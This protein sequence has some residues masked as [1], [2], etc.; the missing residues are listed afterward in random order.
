MSLDQT[1]R[2]WETF[3][4]TDPLW[5]VLGDPTRKGNR[6]NEEE[7]YRT[8]VD[9]VQRTMD[10]LKEFG[11]PVRRGRALDFG[12]GVGRITFPLAQHFDEVVGVDISSAMLDFARTRDRTGKCRFVVNSTPDLSLF[13]DD[14]FDFVYC[15]L[16]L[17]HVEARY[18]PGYI[19]EFIR[20]AAP[21]GAILFQVPT[22]AVDR[23]PASRI[24]RVIPKPMLGSA[25]RIART[26]RR[27]GRATAPIMEDDG[28]RL[29]D[30]L[31]LLKAAGAR[32]LAVKLDQSHG[33]GRPGY[34][35][36]V[37][38]D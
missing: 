9:E 10:A 19:R 14:L 24:A 7:F 6:W 31:E 33:S 2:N 17:Q 22:P 34:E 4:R 3:G 38:P 26:I 5:A 21:R 18:I 27:S 16:V 1:Q 32:V 13:A 15:R 20:V 30:T 23:V 25:R 37:S 8:G 28:I 29:E 36:I 12:C 35:Y 11:V